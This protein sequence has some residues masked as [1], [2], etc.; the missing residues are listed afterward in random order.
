APPAGPRARGTVSLLWPDSSRG[1][2]HRLTN[3]FLRRRL[4]IGT[5]KRGLRLRDRVAELDERIARDEVRLRLEWSGLGSFTDRTELL[6]QLHDHPLRRLLTDAGNRQE[7]RGVLQRNG[8]AQLVRRRAG[9]DRERDLR[10]DTRHREEQ[11]EQLA[12]GG[13]GKGEELQRVLAHVEVGLKDDLSPG[14]GL[15][16]RA[17]GRDDEV[18]DAAHVD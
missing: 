16:A 18:T 6:L 12:L 8:P 14:L 17:G 15:A 3:A 10:A 7:A 13:L 2:L 5:G 11:L 1:L 9:H 4:W